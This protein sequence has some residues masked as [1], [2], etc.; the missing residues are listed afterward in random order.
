MAMAQTLCL[1]VLA[2][3]E[4][5]RNFLRDKGFT[6]TAR[7]VP[8]SVEV[9]QKQQRGDS[10]GKEPEMAYKKPEVVAKSSAK[11]SFAAECPK[12]GLHCTSMRSRML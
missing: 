11:Q 9:K 12:I 5:R 2:S 6:E 3:L 4:R 1:N 7:R 8:M 10:L